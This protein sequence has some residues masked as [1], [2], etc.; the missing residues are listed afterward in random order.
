[1][2]TFSVLLSN[3]LRVRVRV[4]VRNCGCTDISGVVTLTPIQQP[5]SN[6]LVFNYIVPRPTDL[7]AEQGWAFVFDP[8]RVAVDTDPPATWWLPVRIS[9]PST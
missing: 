2:S 9:R 5:S 8:V 6:F 4:R 1:M 3:S 7:K